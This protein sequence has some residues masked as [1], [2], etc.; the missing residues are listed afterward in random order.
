MHG[1]TKKDLSQTDIFK[2]GE[3][4]YHTYRIPALVVS[5]QGTL[6]AFCEARRNSAAD[7]GDIDLALKRSFDN[8]A[9]WEEMQIIWQDGENTIGNPC[10]VVDRDTGT[11]WLPFC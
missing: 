11:I 2:A 8:G 7:D 9:T 1:D 10:P 6:L 4:G 3:D 5:T